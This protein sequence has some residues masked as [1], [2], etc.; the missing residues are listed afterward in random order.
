MQV[1]CVYKT[2]S[3]G[4]IT[5]DIHTGLQ[6]KGI[7]SIVCY[8]R[9]ERVNELGAYKICGEF[10]S[11][12]NHFIAR[13]SGVLYGGCYISTGR[14]ISIIKKEKPDIVHLQCINGYFVNIY[15]LLSW[16][17]CNRI[18]TVVT[19]HAEFMYTG[20]CGHSIDCNQ[21]STCKGCGHSSACPRYRSDMK[22][23]FFDRS[24]TM[25]KRMKKAFESFGDELIITSVSPWLME[26]ASRSSIMNNKKHCVVLN[27]LDT[28]DV[29]KPYGDEAKLRLREEL[30]IGNEKVAFHAT[31][32]FNDNPGH[33]KG[34]YY[35][36][37]LAK[38]MPEVKFVIAGSSKEGM[39]I[40]NNMILLGKITDQKRLAALYSMAD[41]TIL[42]SEKETFSMVTAESLCC[43]TP[44]V[45]F[46][47]GGPEL[48]ALEEYSEF[49]EYKDIEG[50]EKAV[51][52]M[53]KANVNSKDV[54]EKANIYSKEVM[55]ERYTDVYMRLMGE[56]S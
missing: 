56:K 24:A 49:V 5:Y 52:R 3:T 44:V 1:N 43:G 6:E 46:Q 53:L 41:L 50:M 45:G 11:H 8:G 23:Y 35:V 40:P 10:Y 16:L 13:L 47:A 7:D 48:I 20:G 30:K 21:W 38:R 27:G 28:K 22:S 26:R 17:G 29:F 34:G 9:G 18:R 55:V 54:A 33:I 12:V 32:S 39:H 19:L 15:K 36:I 2:G 31:P 14:L 42:A 4:K 51:E 25:W 37:E